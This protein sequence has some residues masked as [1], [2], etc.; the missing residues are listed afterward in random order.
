[1]RAETKAAVE[2]LAA[3]MEATNKIIAMSLR[4][5]RVKG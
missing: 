5:I 4:L 2:K 3:D 1:M